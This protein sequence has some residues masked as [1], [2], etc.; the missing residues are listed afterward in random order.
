MIREMRPIGELRSRPQD[1]VAIDIRPSVDNHDDEEERKE[2]GNARDDLRQRRMGDPSATPDNFLY[3]PKAENKVH[4]E[5]SCLEKCPG[6]TFGCFGC[7][8]KSFCN[9]VKFCCNPKW[10]KPTK[11]RALGCLAAGG[12]AYGTYQLISNFGP[13]VFSSASQ[14]IAAF[15]FMNG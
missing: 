2:Q 14:A 1:S 3:V 12:L 9:D 10:L 5:R 8:G 6:Y 15:V 7:S 13:E 11:R 4:D